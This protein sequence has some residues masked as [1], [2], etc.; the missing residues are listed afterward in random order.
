MFIKFL[1]L[2]K[3]SSL[4]FVCIHV[5]IEFL[6]LYKYSP[7]IFICIYV[8]SSPLLVLTL[9]MPF[10]LLDKHENK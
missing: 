4:V 3:F 7:L 5:F 6:L 1:L 8:F 2:Y 9:Q 10:G